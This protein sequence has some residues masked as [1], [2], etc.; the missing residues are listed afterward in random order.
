MCKYDQWV[1]AFF[2]LTATSKTLPHHKLLMM[3]ADMNYGASL[4]PLELLS[5]L[6]LVKSS[7]IFSWNKDTTHNTRLQVLCSAVSS[8]NECTLHEY[9]I[10]VS[11]IYHATHIPHIR[12]MIVFV[13]KRDKFRFTVGLV[14]IVT[15]QLKT[16]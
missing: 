14:F 3:F 10:N 8:Y 12:L 2:L 7:G 5:L 11:K 9:T 4:N 6:L 1:C 15:V 13:P 16:S